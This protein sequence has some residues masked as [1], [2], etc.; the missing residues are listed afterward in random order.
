MASKDSVLIITDS[1][2]KA[3]EW[4]LR[5]F[6]ELNQPYLRLSTDKLFGKKLVLGLN[7]TGNYGSLVFGKRLEL[8][9]V[10]SVWIR[11]PSIPELPQFLAGENRRFALNEYEGFLWSLYTNIDAF[12]VN[13]PSALRLLE[14]NKVRQLSDAA[15]VGLRVPAT[16]VT[17]SST[18]L[19]RF[20]ERLGGAIAVKAIRPFAATELSGS[21]KLIYTNKVGREYLRAHKASIR[22]AP[23]FAQE[24]IEK[25][26]ELRVTVVGE[27]V[28][29]CAIH[30]Q[31]SARTKDDWR[32]YDFKRV[33]HHSHTLDTGVAEKLL[34][35][36]KLWGLVYGAFDLIITPEG[37]HVFLEV[38]PSGQWTWIE[39][40]TGMPISQ[41]LAELLICPPDDLL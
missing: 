33:R 6:K 2:E 15:G 1:R 18:E 36:M 38:N 32:R 23:V 35:L 17:N 10:K 34:R 4:V 3:V 20:C 11:H 5:W 19:M 39:A 25:D 30:S 28:F 27:K 12:W 8:D 22:L 29:S 7:G 16:I 24:Y 41:A 14:H 40:F 21:T 31:D 9:R 13:S 37:D 26:V